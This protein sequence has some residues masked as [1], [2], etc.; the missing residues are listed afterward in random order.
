MGFPVIGRSDEKKI[1]LD[2]IGSAEPE[3]VAVY[4]RRR[5]GKTYLIR[6]YLKKQ[7]I[8]EFSGTDNA[9]LNQQL[10][11]ISLAMHKATGIQMPLANPKKWQEVFKLSTDYISPQIKKEKSCFF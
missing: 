4:G 11:N 9:S 5:V 1:L 2:V 6:N 7:L 10:E 8:F 3:L